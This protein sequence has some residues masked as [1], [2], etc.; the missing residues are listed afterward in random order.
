MSKPTFCCLHVTLKGSIPW[1]FPEPVPWPWA[2]ARYQRFITRC[3]G[4]G[5]VDP[6]GWSTC[7][8]GDPTG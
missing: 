1:L 6:S 2:A 7:M 5:S 8:P 4:N 3:Q